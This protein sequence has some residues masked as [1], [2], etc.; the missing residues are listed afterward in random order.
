MLVMVSSRPS[1]SDTL[2]GEI[3]NL[4]ENPENLSSKKRILYE[5]EKMLNMQEKNLEIKAL[6]RTSGRTVITNR[7]LY[8]IV[9]A[10]C[11]EKNIEPRVIYT[12]NGIIEKEKAEKLAEGHE[13][14]MKD[15]ELTL[16]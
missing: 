6:N 8:K 4:R 5:I 7:M 12:G 2:D 16:D 13:K 3:E 11:S 9:K 15:F 14:E 10:L 1:I